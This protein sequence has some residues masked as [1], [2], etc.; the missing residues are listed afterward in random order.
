MMSMLIVT[1][2]DVIDLILNFTAI[3]FIGLLGKLVQYRATVSI[4]LLIV[5]PVL[6][7]SSLQ[8]FC[9]DT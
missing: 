3:E 7:D 9:Y 1:S 4:V 5:I 8:L 2:S 6:A